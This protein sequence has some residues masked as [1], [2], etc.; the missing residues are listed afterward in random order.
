MHK[1]TRINKILIALTIGFCSSVSAYATD[2]YTMRTSTLMQVQQKAHKT[3]SPVMYVNQQ[4]G[5]IT[6]A[7]DKK[8]AKALSYQSPHVYYL[9][10]GQTVSQTIERWA[11][12]NGY[13]VF[14]QSPDDYQIQANSIIYGEFLAKGGAL[15]TL[16]DSLKSSPTPYKAEVMANKVILIKPGTFSSSFLMPQ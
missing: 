8:Q 13:T 11:K 10:E 15:N 3:L 1:T 12:L 4:S 16:L 14:F 7:A 6:F 9:I 5:L 2:H